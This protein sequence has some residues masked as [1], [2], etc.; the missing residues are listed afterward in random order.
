MFRVSELKS[1]YDVMTTEKDMDKK[2]AI[3]LNKVL[4]KFPS[5]FHEWFLTTF[6]SPTKW[7]VV[8]LYPTS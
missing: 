1:I 4:P 6:L 5:V 7:L 3:F 2:N 8:S